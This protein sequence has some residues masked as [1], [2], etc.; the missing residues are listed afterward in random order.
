MLR[1]I[2]SL[3]TYGEK[4]QLSL[5]LLGI[6]LRSVIEVAGVASIMPF[7]AVVANQ[8][9]IYTNKYLSMI[10]R[11]FDFQSPRA[12]LI[13]LGVL[14]FCIIIV[15]NLLSALTE[16]FLIR[17]SWLRG[18][19]LARRLFAKYLSQPYAF[20]LNENTVNLGANILNEVGT[21]LKGV[22]LPFIQMIARGIVSIFF[23]IMLVFVDPLLAIIVGMVLGSAYF[24]LFMAVRKKL[25]KVGNERALA[26]RKQFLYISE[27]LT[28]IKDVKV[29]GCE[30][31]FLE[32]FSGHSYKVDRKSVV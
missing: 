13:F 30:N 19:T 18:H 2:L 27:A 32:E 28:G 8:E 25:V 7:I 17:F 21:F 9:I 5:L 4:L 24:L 15:N 16:W 3:F 6:V 31:Y 12:F 10:Y 11:I 20:F 1:K 23:F 14:V 26:Y 29:K 22:L